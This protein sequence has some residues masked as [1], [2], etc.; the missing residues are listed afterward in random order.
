MPHDITDKMSSYHVTSKELT[1][2][3]FVN[4][5]SQNSMLANASE[6]GA[7]LRVETSECRVVSL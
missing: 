6:S 4:T 3:N 5:T 2:K 1:T 7:E